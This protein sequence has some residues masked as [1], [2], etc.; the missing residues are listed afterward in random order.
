VP[1]RRYNQNELG[2]KNRFDHEGTSAGEQQPKLG[3]SPAKTQRPQK[4]K[5][6]DLAFLASWREQISVLDSNGPP[7]NLRKLETFWLV[8]QT[9]VRR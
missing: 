3:I 9:Y 6:P 2:E 7:E 8:V 4:I 5:L 1:Q